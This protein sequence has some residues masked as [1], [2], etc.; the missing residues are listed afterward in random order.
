MMHGT[1]NVKFIN[2]KQAIEV[3]Q[4]S[5]IKR[6]LYK[7]NAAIWY[8]KTCRQNHLKPTYVNI[9]INGNNTQ[10]Q[11]T[12][13]SAT[14]CRKTRE[15][16]TSDI[17]LVI[18]KSKAKVIVC[19]ESHTSSSSSSSSSIGPT[20]HCGLWPVEQFPSIF[21]YL[22]PTLSIFSLSALE[23]LFLLPLSIFSWVLRA[24]QNT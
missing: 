10:C 16:N 20:A 4:Y 3:Y 7:T 9:R 18:L 23:D 6:K 17:V 1:M 14:K 12:L 22:P 8:N 5:N 15:I 19:S 13:K 24:T 21:S 11:K 2:A